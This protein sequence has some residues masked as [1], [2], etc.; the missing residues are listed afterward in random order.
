MPT[1]RMLLKIVRKRQERR[2]IRPGAARQ[3]D[4]EAGQTHWLMRSWSDLVHACASVLC[5]RKS[6]S[7][8]ASAG[9][10]STTTSPVLIG[11]D[12]GGTAMWRSLT[13]PGPG[14]GHVALPGSLRGQ[15][16]RRSVTH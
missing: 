6:A 10:G 7:R 16:C 11:G 5:A 2:G 4:S 15:T 13:V 1:H 9:E 12:S 3:T 14:K 8:S